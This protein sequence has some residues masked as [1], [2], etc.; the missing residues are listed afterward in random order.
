MTLD[1]DESG[2]LFG[3]K[4]GP[5]VGSYLYGL[6][7]RARARRTDPETSHAAARSIT[8]LRESQRDVLYMFLTYGEMTDVDLCALAKDRCISQSRSGLRTRRRELVD[9][10]YLVDTGKRRKLDTGRMAI[11]WAITRSDRGG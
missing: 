11:V 8:N 10:G 6:S 3:E 5:P 2:D 7:E 1:N 9:G 4:D